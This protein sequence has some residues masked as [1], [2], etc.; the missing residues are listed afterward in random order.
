MR[1]QSTK[2]TLLHPC[3]VALGSFPL[4]IMPV[5]NVLI[6]IA[7]GHH[8]GYRCPGAIQVFE[9]PY[10]SGHIETGMYAYQI[11]EMQIQNRKIEKMK[12]GK[13]TKRSVV[14]YEFRFV[15]IH[16]VITCSTW[17]RYAPNVSMIQLVRFMNNFPYGLYIVE[18]ARTDMLLISYEIKPNSRMN[19]KYYTLIT[20]DC[21]IIVKEFETDTRG[22]LVSLDIYIYI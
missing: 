20:E 1:N 14:N 5:R 22:F 17:R 19:F 2:C 8:G 6:P 4:L 11:F 15:W 9:T 21:T 18:A 12:R 10:S 7:I 3:D 16:M 13:P